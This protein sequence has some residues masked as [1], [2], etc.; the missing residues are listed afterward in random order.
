M[1]ETLPHKPKHQLAPHELPL[2]FAVCLDLM[3][4]GMILPDLQT[5]M[6]AFGANGLLIG[7]VYAVYFLVQMTASPLWGR[8]SDKSGRKPVLLI[9]GLLSSVSMG[10][11]AVSSGIGL[12]VF[13][14]ILAGLGGA[15]V[16]AAQAYLA[17]TTPEGSRTQAM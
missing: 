13:S 15:N 2:L 11:Y 14:R 16:T 7:S 4:F 12:I 9:C 3:G 6:E 8:W 10:L 5:R 1:Q 17:D